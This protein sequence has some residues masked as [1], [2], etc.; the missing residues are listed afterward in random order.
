VGR[1]SRGFIFHRDHRVNAAANV[2]IPHHRHGFRTGGLHQ[3]IEDSIDDIFVK[4]ALF[5]ERPEIKLERLKLNAQVAGNVTDPDRGKIRLT[6]AGTHA[7][8]LGAFHADL[9]VPT[10]ARVRKGLQIF[11]G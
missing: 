5:T 7:G 8:K 4:G 6:G 1:F 2:K 11:T 10:R 9:I 3:V